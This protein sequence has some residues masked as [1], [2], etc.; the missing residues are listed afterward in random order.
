MNKKIA[1]ISCSNAN[2]EYFDH[3]YDIKIF[4][5]T[6]HL[7]DENYLDH[8]E[9]SAEDFYKRLE[10]DKSIFPSTSFMPL[11]QM[12]GIYE[13]LVKE[14]YTDAIVITISKEDRKSVV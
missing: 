8:T 3:D 11:G 5:S 6:L 2:L 12:I 4:R 14:G 1:I 7:G 13:E 10:E 9:I